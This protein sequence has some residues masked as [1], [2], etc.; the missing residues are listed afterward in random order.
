MFVWDFF[1]YIRS[2]SNPMLLSSNPFLLMEM[3]YVNKDDDD[4]GIRVY[5]Y[6][7]Y[8]NYAK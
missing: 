4:G 7:Y 2:Y 5:Y 6:G 1:L 8:T 3:V